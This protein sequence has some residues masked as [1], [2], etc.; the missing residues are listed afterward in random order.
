MPEC[1]AKARAGSRG[2]HWPTWESGRWLLLGQ[3]QAVLVQLWVQV[4]QEDA[5]LHGHLLLLRVHLQETSG[6]WD[7][8]GRRS[9]LVLQPHRAV[10]TSMSP[11][12]GSQRGA[13]RALACWGF[14]TILHNPSFHRG[15]K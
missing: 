10:S 11:A 7:E 12:A 1:P 15:K 2:H 3:S 13:G 8:L 9:V 4:S 6:D 5:G 14:G